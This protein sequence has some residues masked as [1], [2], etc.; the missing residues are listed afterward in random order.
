VQHPKF[1]LGTILRTEGSGDEAK[2]TVSF[3]N[4]G[5]KKM[6]AKYASLEEVSGGKG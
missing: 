1:G 2:L 5:L 6:V 3:S 4:F